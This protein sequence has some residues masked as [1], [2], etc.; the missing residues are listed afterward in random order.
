M[1]VALPRMETLEETPT[2]GK[3]V[4]EPLERGYG[5]TLGNSLRRVMLS[6]IEGAAITAVKID[7]VLHEFSE[8]PGLKEDTTE[9]LLNLKNLNLRVEP[10]AAGRA[11]AHTVRIERRGAGRITG[12]DVECPAGVEVVNPECYIATIADDNASLSMEMVVEVGKG[13]VLP[14]KQEQRPG[15]PIGVIPVGSAFTP[16]RKVNYTV[17]PRRVGFKTDYERL[18]LDIT[19]NGTMKPSAAISQ[20]AMILDRFYRH[21]ME[22]APVNVTEGDDSQEPLRPAEFEPQAA[23]DMLV[24]AGIN[25]RGKL[26][27]QDV[28]A[29]RGIEGF[30]QEHENAVKEWMRKH[31]AQQ[32]GEA[33]AIGAILPGGQA[34]DERIEEMEFSVRTHNCLKRANILTIGELVQTTESELMQIKNFGVKSLNEVRTKLAQRDLALRGEEVATPKNTETDRVAQQP[35]V[36]PEEAGEQDAQEPGGSDE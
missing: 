2:F 24:R 6:A 14:D 3:F 29:L 12:A 5:V 22:L 25:T 21:F 36:L 8:I 28:K 35:Q 32:G 13:Y 9:L 17:E 33:L 31:P 7:G 18:V 16:V 15:Q 19:T 27:A 1:E 10:S 4:V 26:R 34:A 11:E 30:G 20:A 23:Y